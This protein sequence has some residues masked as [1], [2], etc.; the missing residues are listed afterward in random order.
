[1]YGIMLNMIYLQSNDVLVIIFEQ[2]DA[3]DYR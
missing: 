3:I 2:N 1:M